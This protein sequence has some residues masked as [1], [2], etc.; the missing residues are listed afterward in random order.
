MTENIA[1]LKGKKLISKTTRSLR[2][3]LIVTLLFGRQI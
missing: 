2:Y 1:Q 3:T